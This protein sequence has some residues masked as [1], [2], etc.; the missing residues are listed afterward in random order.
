LAAM[1][2][3][4]GAIIAIT[5]VMS[6][7]FVP[8]AFLSGPVGVFYRQ[9]SLTLA[10]S[11]LISGINALTLTPALCAIILRSPHDRPEPRGAL[12]T[13]FRKFN[14]VYN[15]ISGRYAGLISRIAGMPVIT[16]DILVVSFIATSSIYSVLPSGFIPTEDQGM[17]Y[18]NVTTPPG[19]TV[20][21]TEAVLDE[22]DAIARQ[23]ESVE[24]VSTLAGYSLVNEVTG[25]SYG[26]GMIN[27]KRWEE[28]KESVSDMV[29]H[30]KKETAKITDAEIEFFPPPTVPGFGN[31]SVFE[32]RVLDRSGSDDLGKLSDVLNTFMDNLKKAPEVGSAF[33]SFD[34]NFPQY[35]I[36]VDYDVAAKKG[37]SV[38]NAMSTLQTL[39]GS[40]YTSNF[41]KFGQMYNVMVQAGPGYREK[42]EDVLRLFLKN[43][44]GEMVPFSS[45]I[46]MER[47]YGPE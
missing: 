28:R 2:E 22:V 43:D 46:K 25:A 10:G 8:V 15:S 35:M 1:R 12:A 16:L 4:S 3:I 42:P 37:I 33:T 11:I 9:F 40:F 32:L 17:I 21:R 29:E 41:I 19:A 27:L 36:N 31:S 20:Q 45:F 44:A 14:S 26:M 7:V 30:M 38:E 5:L 23:M 6:A 34:P 18:V 13:F 47:I 39:M 24:S